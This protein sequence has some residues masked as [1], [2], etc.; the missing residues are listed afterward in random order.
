MNFDEKVELIQLLEARTLSDFERRKRR[1]LAAQARLWG[2][3]AKG[4]P[5]LSGLA[6][7]IAK[8]RKEEGPLTRDE[9]IVVNFGFLPGELEAIV[10]QEEP[11]AAGGI[12]ESVLNEWRQLRLTNPSAGGE[13]VTR[14]LQA[15]KGADGSRTATRRETLQQ[16]GAVVQ[17]RDAALAANVL[18][19][20]TGGADCT[21]DLALVQ[22]HPKVSSGSGKL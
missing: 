13:G 18:R 20:Q 1:M 10:E 17:R 22:R 14:M 2:V 19:C 21:A 11:A 5:S 9:Y 15:A 12:A 3:D 16:L 8:A 4:A 7:L 6:D